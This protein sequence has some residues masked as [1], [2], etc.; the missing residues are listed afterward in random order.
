MQNANI[1]NQNDNLKSQNSKYP[2]W[3]R[4]NLKI[5]SQNSKST[6]KRKTQSAKGKTTT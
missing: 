6:F 3:Y 1:K 4:A 2:T 5:T